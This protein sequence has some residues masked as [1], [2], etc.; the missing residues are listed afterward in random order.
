MR[1][2]DRR[3]GRGGQDRYDR[4]DRYEPARRPRWRWA[5]AVVAAVALGGGAAAVTQAVTPEGTVDYHAG[6]DI[7]QQAP[8]LEEFAGGTVVPSR[9]GLD[10]ALAPLFADGGLGS[11]VAGS[12]ADALTGE[13]LWDRG[14]DQ[15]MTPAS[16]AKLLTAAAVLTTRGPNYRIPTRV[17][18][19]A[20]PGEVVLVGGGDPTLALGEVSAYRGAARL[21]QLAEQVRTSLGGT[22]PSRV[23]I[24]TTLFPGPSTH[25]SWIEADVTG[26]V[27]SHVTALMTDGARV[28][29]TDTRDNPDHHAQPDLAAGRLFA[30]ALGVPVDQVVAGGSA[31]QGARVLGEVLSPPI[32]RIVERM[33]VD[34]DNVVAELMARQAALAQ[35]LPASF[36]G[37][38]QAQR[39]AL[40]E[41]GV[42]TP[43]GVGLVDGS[44][45]SDDNKVTTNQLVALLRAAMSPEHPELSALLSGL[46]VAGYSGTLD[47]RGRAGLGVVRA[48]T[49]TLSHVNA[50]AGYVIDADGRLLVFAVVAD[51]TDGR[52]AAENA[53]DKIASGIGGCGCR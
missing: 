11:N 20:N 19:G 43:A 44:G 17:V 38:A 22:A 50:L 41:L 29:P 35:G 36:D 40:A 42:P 24:D 15:A 49:G 34:S 16:A 51:A 21:D 25:P 4:M 31:P 45:L 14:G 27:I 18:A 39:A 23:I 26:G 9:G 3:S 32:G 7:G 13:V 48:K 10:A 2:P 12:V 46:P 5:A 30:Q 1:V 37:A 52:F 8:V 6:V 28:N 33:L 53:L 47:E